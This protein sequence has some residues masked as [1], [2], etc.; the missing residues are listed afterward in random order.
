MRIIAPSLTEVEVPLLLHHLNIDR[1][2]LEIVENFH[3]SLFWGELG[4]PLA[5]E[6]GRIGKHEFCILSDRSRN[7]H[8]LEVSLGDVADEIVD[9]SA[10]SF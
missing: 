9:F 8:I 3:L 7:E 2:L 4:C 1:N 10:T 5:L 6:E